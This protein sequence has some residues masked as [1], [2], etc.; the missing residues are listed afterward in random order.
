MEKSKNRKHISGFCIFLAVVFF[1]WTGILLWSGLKQFHFSDRL[2]KEVVEL[3]LEKGGAKAD[4]VNYLQADSSKS[5]FA[6]KS[7]SQTNVLTYLIENEGEIP[8]EAESQVVELVSLFSGK[9]T[10]ETFWSTAA[11]QK[12]RE[13]ELFWKSDKKIAQ[14][15]EKESIVAKQENAEEETSAEEKAKKET[16]EETELPETEKLAVPVQSIVLFQNGSPDITSMNNEIVSR[17]E[18]MDTDTAICDSKEELAANLNMIHKLEKSYSRSYM[19]QKFFITDSS[20]SIDNAIF[21]AKELLNMDLT[22]KKKKEPQILILHTHGASEAFVDSRKGKKE[23]SIIGVGTEL[24]RILSKKYG[25]QV[26]HDKTEYD[27]ING[28]IDRNKAYN[29]AYRGLQ[30]TLK[31][32]PSIDIVIDL[33]RD[34][35]GNN[36]KRTTV[37]N[38]KRTAQAMFFNGLSRNASGDIAYLQNDNLQG[39]LAFSLQLK[40]A[41]MKRFVDFARPVYLKGYRY[42]MHLRKRY[43]LIELGNENNTVQ[44]QKNAAAPL[45]MVIDAVLQ[46]K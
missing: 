41:S 42:N 2:Q 15:E 7:L 38:G 20:T 46:G 44:E 3:F 40:I 27:K 5:V 24:A 22:V 43:T 17:K 25:Y 26:L 33:H 21:Q 45:A 10:N 28:K 13:L 9:N 14:L 8:D 30:K 1:A 23:D 34:G 31:K 36:V 16:E 12:A 6:K 11:S 29:N 19:L 4:L 32:Y 18:E 37:L 39:N 35:V